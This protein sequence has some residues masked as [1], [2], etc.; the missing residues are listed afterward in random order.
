MRMKAMVVAF[1][2]LA[3]ACADDG[4]S[5][6]PSAPGI[7]AVMVFENGPHLAQCAPPA[8][9]RTQSAAKLTSAGIEVRSSSCGHRKGIAYPA[10][11]GGG[12][13]EILL[14]EI[15]ASNIAEARARG[16]TPAGELQEGWSAISC[17]QYLHAIEVA[18][19]TTSC[20]EIRNRVLSIQN[21]QQP[22]DRV[23]LLD[24]AGNCADAGYRQVLFGSAG[25]NVLCSNA[26]SIAGPRKSCAEA[27][28]AKLFDTILENLDR[29]DLGLGSGYTVGQVYPAN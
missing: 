13:A 16:F 3:A 27:G 1:G 12:T 6:P 7:D 4:T 22:Q 15:P 29:P 8:I 26:D 17:P 5:P 20:V 23:I 18:Q 10:V 2:L 25:D 11:C 21:N 19:A 24:Q 14:H 9:T 28:R